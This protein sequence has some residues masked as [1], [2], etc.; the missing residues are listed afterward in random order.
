MPIETGRAARAPRVITLD[1]AADGYQ[2][3]LRGRPETAGMR[4]GLV[5][6][7]PGASVG[8][9]NT[10]AHEEQL[11]V[12]EGE[13]EFRADGAEPLAINTRSTVYCPP[14]C[15]HDVVN[16]GQ[17]PLRYIYVVAEAG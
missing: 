3:L 15:E 1:L 13:G 17:L 8:T 2:A 11:V 6:L 12:L 16:T 10:G 5:V 14:H 4:S 7:K 9:H